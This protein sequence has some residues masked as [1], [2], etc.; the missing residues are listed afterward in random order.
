MIY[1]ALSQS[2]KQ[3]ELIQ[4][5]QLKLNFSAPPNPAHDGHHDGNGGLK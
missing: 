5:G 1:V 4:S 2:D 3:L